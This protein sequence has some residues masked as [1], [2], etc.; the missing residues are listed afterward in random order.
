MGYAHYVLPDGREAG[1]GV[2]ATCDRDDCE[3]EIDRGLGFLCGNNPDGWRDDTEPGCG[4]YFCDR[5]TYDHD[6][7]HP[8]GDDEHGVAGPANR[9]VQQ[10]VDGYPNGPSEV[11]G[12]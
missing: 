7:P 1:Y 12:P 11:S 5:H 9:K 6:C 4:R 10:P 2:D 8:E 3:E